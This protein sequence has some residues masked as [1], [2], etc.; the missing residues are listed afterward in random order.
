M[1]TVTLHSIFQAT[2]C[3]EKPTEKEHNKLQQSSPKDES[4]C[5]GTAVENQEQS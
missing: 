2:L 1:L 5:G 3:G 4:E